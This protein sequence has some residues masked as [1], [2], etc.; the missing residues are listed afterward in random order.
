M[1]KLLTTLTLAAA[2]AAPA[3]SASAQVFGTTCTLNDV[4]LTG[5]V[6]S[7][8]PLACWGTDILLPAPADMDQNDTESEAAGLLAGYT[9]ANDVWSRVGKSDVAGFGPF[10][11]NPTSAGFVGFDNAISGWFGL[12]LKAGG[13]GQSGG[14]YH[15]YIFNVTSGA[16]NGFN[17]SN[18]P[19]G[20]GLS[21]VSLY[22]AD[23]RCGSTTVPE[24]ASLAL[25]AT[26]MVGLV[27]I[28]RRRRA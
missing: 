10:T 17:Y 1:K 23:G 21:H 3:A 19:G 5:G 14:G 6:I 22:C 28:A 25:L 13:G 8:G 7:S 27:G 2:L 16:A 18:L 11:G 24:P 15:L 9:V 12:A 26:G 20:Q 4:T